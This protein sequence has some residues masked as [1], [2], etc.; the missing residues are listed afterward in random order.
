M[1]V[2]ARARRGPFRSC[3]VGR[4]EFLQRPDIICTETVPYSNSLSQWMPALLRTNVM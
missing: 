3:S 4:R 1:S 2:A